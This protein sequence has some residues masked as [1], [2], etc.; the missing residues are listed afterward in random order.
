[1]LGTGETTSSARCTAEENPPT[2]AMSSDNQPDRRHSSPWSP[3]L[4]PHKVPED[5]LSRKAVPGTLHTTDIWGGVTLWPGRPGH[6]RMLSSTPWPPPIDFPS[7]RP[8]RCLSPG[9]RITPAENHCLSLWF[10]IFQCFRAWKTVGSTQGAPLFCGRGNRVL[11]SPQ[12]TND[13]PDLLAPGFLPVAAAGLPLPPP[14]NML[15]LS[16]LVGEGGIEGLHSHL[17]HRDSCNTPGPLL[18]RLGS[19]WRKVCLQ[20]CRKFRPSRQRPVRRRL[21]MG[22]RLRCCWTGGFFKIFRISRAHCAGRRFL[23]L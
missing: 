7:P 21:R 8:C 9:A 14:T 13:N 10:E 22:H 18:P 19:W 11:R 16:P 3:M 4:G 5:T 1:M 6:C 12:L 15:T 2:N 23:R 17:L 20:A